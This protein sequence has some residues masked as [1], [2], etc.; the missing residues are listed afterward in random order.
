MHNSF[1]SGSR[2]CQNGISSAIVIPFYLKKAKFSEIHSKN[3]VHFKLIG[4]NLCTFDAIR[5]FLTMIHHLAEV[6]NEFYWDHPN[7]ASGFGP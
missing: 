5:N 3:N 2:F 4:N 7:N 1:Y 6:Q